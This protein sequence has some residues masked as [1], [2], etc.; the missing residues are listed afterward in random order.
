M[1][2]MKLETVI[3]QTGNEIKT[4]NSQTNI[5]IL[6]VIILEISWRFEQFMLFIKNWKKWK[7]KHWF[8]LTFFLPFKKIH[9]TFSWDHVVDSG[10]IY[11]F[12]LETKFTNCH[13]HTISKSFSKFHEDPSSSYFSL[14]IERKWKKIEK[15]CVFDF[16]YQITFN[17]KS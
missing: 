14:T 7:K 1:K 2:R 15:M 16:A 6:L 12:N 9:T 17:S 10:K 13:V 11:R 8:F 4:Q 5:F 3:S